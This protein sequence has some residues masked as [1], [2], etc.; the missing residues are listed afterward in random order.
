MKMRYSLPGLAVA[1]LAIAGFAA[2]AAADAVADFY[3]GKTITVVVAAGPGGGH[4][5]YTQYLAPFLE[6]FQNKR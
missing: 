4:T 3:K 1:A 2:P 5:Q 6:K